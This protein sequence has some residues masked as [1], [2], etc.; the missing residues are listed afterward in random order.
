VRCRG[1]AKVD[2]E[3]LGQAFFAPFLAKNYLEGLSAERGRFRAFLPAALKNFLR[4]EGKHAQ[5]LK[6]GPQRSKLVIGLGDGGYEISGGSD[7]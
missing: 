4:K 7:E 3:D 2:A 6:R 1:H 5:Q